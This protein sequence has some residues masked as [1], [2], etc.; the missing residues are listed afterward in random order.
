[1]CSVNSTFTN[2][3]KMTC[4]YSGVSTNI[5]I[6]I[7][8]VSFIIGLPGNAFVIWTML[9][10]MKK[11]TVTCVLILHLA[12]ADI[13]VLLT[14]PF[15]LHVLSTGSWIFGNIFCKM[16]FYICSLTMYT[17]VF[18]ITLMSIDRFLAVTQPF[19]SQKLRTTQIVRVMIALIWVLASLLSC[20][21]FFYQGEARCNGHLQCRPMHP[22][23]NH[24]VFQYTF[25]IL[26][27]FVI[28]FTII[29]SCYVFIGLRLRTARFP[30]KQKTNRL[31][32]MIIVMFAL[33]WLPY[34]IVNMLQV[35]GEIFSSPSLTTAALLARPNVIAFAFLSSSANPI[36]YVFAGGNFIKTAGV[37]FMAKLFEA[38]A[39]E[40]LSLRKISQALR[41]RSRTESVEL[42]KCVKEAEQNKST[43]PNQT[44]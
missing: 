32:I 41:Q 20:A 36:L 34:Q 44:D 43:L 26:N 23:P 19:T 39:F 16:C 38:T 33:F 21:I 15:F 8:S 24:M 27:G 9:T 40:V 5:G 7:L 28:P 35:S 13:I 10:Q 42:D 22:S 25:E 12:V 37:G 30:T 18:L 11:R 3:S 4:L 14:A 17:S 2:S 29:V 31:I 6:A 1:M